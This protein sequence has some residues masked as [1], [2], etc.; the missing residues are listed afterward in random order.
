MFE[1]DGLCEKWKRIEVNGGGGFTRISVAKLCVRQKY[2]IVERKSTKVG[3]VLN[4]L[5]L[6]N[7]I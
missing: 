3:L 2:G 6:G 4:C 1:T 7:M 5:A